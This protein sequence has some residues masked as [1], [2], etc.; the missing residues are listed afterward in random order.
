[1]MNHVWRP[2]WLLRRTP[3]DLSDDQNTTPKT[4]TTTG[5]YCNS[6]WKQECTLITRIHP[7]PLLENVVISSLGN[8]VTLLPCTESYVSLPT[9]ERDS[10]SYTKFCWV[11]DTSLGHKLWPTNMGKIIIG[12]VL[13]DTHHAF[14]HLTMAVLCCD[15]IGDTAQLHKK[16]LTG[17]THLTVLLWQWTI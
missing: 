8:T 13:Y 10:V 3:D 17:P 5:G 11:P 7:W 4:L 15:K 16:E 1:M 6:S 9:W 2:M 14:H 12:R